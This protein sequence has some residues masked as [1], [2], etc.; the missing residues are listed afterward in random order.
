MQWTLCLSEHLGSKRGAVKHSPTTHPYKISFPQTT[1]HFSYFI[2][3]QTLFYSSSLTSKSWPVFIKPT[4]NQYFLQKSLLTVCL[5]M[6]SPNNDRTWCQYKRNPNI[7]VIFQVRLPDPFWGTQVGPHA[8]NPWSHHI[9]V[10]C[11][12]TKNRSPGTWTEVGCT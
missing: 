8:Q 11:R 4:R 6:M 12:L 10:F 2:S 5:G 9:K 1:Q 3:F 7:T